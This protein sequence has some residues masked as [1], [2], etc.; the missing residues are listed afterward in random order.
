MGLHVGKIAMIVSIERLLA[1]QPVL[2][3]GMQ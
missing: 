2:F 3:L 1:S